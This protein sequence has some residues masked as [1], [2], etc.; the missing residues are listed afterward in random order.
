MS[1]TECTPSL[2][3]GEEGPAASTES[4]SPTGT[5][6]LGPREDERSRRTRNSMLWAAYGDALGFISELADERLLRRRTRGET[7][8]RLMPWSRRVGG[9]SGVEVQLPAGCWSDD[10][11]LRL[12]V[13]R[14]LSDRGFDTETFANVE[15]PTWPSYALGGGRASKAASKN[16]ANPRVHWYTNTFK[17]WTDAGGN[18]A[19]MRIQPHVWAS[20]R[21][22]ER[23]YLVPVI[24]DSVCTHGHP[25]AL[26]G[27]CFH[28]VLLAHCLMTGDAPS[29]DTAQDIATSL[30]G[31]AQT[32]ERHEFLGVFWVDQWEATSGQTLCQGWDAAVREIVDA[33]STSR[34][35]VRDADNAHDA[36]ER[37]CRDLGLREKQRAGSGVLTTVA[38]AA[39]AA[40][41]DD[42]FNGS[43]IA[44]NALGT[45]TDTIASMAGALLGAGDRALE[46]PQA[47]LDSGLLI[48]E[49]ARLRALAAGQPRPGHTYPDLLRWSAPSTQADALVRNEHGLAI[50][51]LGPVSEIDGDPYWSSR[52]DF[53]WRWV[54]TCFNQTLLVKSRPTPP[55]QAAGNC[56]VDR[57]NEARA[58][59]I[60]PKAR[61]ATEERS[62]QSRSSDEVSR[63]RKAFGD[64][65]S[66]VANRS[67]RAMPESTDRDRD[68]RP[69]RSGPRAQSTGMTTE[70]LTKYAEHARRVVKDDRTLVDMLR[71]VARNGTP[72]DLAYVATNLYDDLRL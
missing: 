41:A 34:S 52:R 54:K 65:Q 31:S 21:L 3:L 37:V 33:I 14:S 55:K 67:P 43:V 53:A 69:S 56:I 20:E 9:R 46:P 45:D 50:E 7:L 17:G 51:G 25:R 18:G 68:I 5:L 72:A 6:D 30:E 38:A 12:A 49:A 15:L 40:I 22:I 32:I 57:R 44:A 61:D 2:P 71:Q 58:E 59:R 19:A 63:Q 10:T 39:L 47:P 70:Q 4:R 62:L 29:L 8:D 13:C 64:V 27:A 66:S 11:Q 23:D 42:A 28:A 60:P 36:Y 24:E 1:T 26:V 35:A 16:L 48:D